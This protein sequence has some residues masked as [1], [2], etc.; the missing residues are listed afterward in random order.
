MHYFCC[1]ERRREAVRAH[2]TL[3]GIDFLDVRRNPEP[4]QGRSQDVLVV[5]FVKPF[6]REIAP[7]HILIE[8]GER[9]RQVAVVAVEVGQDDKAHMLTILLDKTGDSSLYTLR[10]VEYDHTGKIRPLNGIDIL[11]SA[12]DF[13]FHAGEND[14]LDCQQESSCVPAYS[15]SP[16][17]DY[18]AKDYNSFRLMM[19][20]RLTQLMP[21]WSERSAPI[22]VLCW[23]SY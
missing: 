10:L 13:F 16:E 1:E 3:N 15:L 11:M 4:F 23:L 9:I 20:D 21:Q 17:I 6:Q 14:N 8:G 22:L 12:V 19:L 7:Q 2:P 5:S 18:L